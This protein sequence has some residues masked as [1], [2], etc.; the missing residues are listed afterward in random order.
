[1]DSLEYSFIHLSATDSMKVNKIVGSHEHYYKLRDTHA[2]V[3][4]KDLVCTTPELLRF[5]EKVVQAYPLWTF[6]S[7]EMCP[8]GRRVLP[9]NWAPPMSDYDMRNVFTTVALAPGE[10]N[11]L[12]VFK[13]GEALPEGYTTQHPLTFGVHV[14]QWEVFAFH[15]FDEHQQPIGEVAYYPEDG[16]AR[17]YEHGVDCDDERYR[18]C[19]HGRPNTFYL[20][21][22]DMREDRLRGSIT[23]TKNFSKAVRLC[24]QEFAPVPIRQ[25]VNDAFSSLVTHLDTSLGDKRHTFQMA[26]RAVTESMQSH[27]CDNWH[28]FA[29]VCL[30]A[31]LSEDIA[32]HFTEGKRQYDE[33]DKL[34]HNRDCAFVRLRPEGV[35]HVKR[36]PTGW[37]NP[38]SKH[39]EVEVYTTAT[40]PT[41]WKKRIAL[42]KMCE[43]EQAIGG[44]GYRHTSTS[45]YITTEDTQDAEG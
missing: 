40:L 29:E 20:D 15:V 36:R 31:G 11:Q 35:Y 38:S 42:L 37:L 6:V 32:D 19:P 8:M 43:N 26:W 12:R 16:T 3:T 21:C 25:Q 7:K 39:E 1:M 13:H 17:T 30:K 4:G 10:P 9:D 18:T 27:V 45:F 2:T 44:V 22:Y 28:D 23:Y 14:K 5:V 34:K 24:K 33:L 41:N